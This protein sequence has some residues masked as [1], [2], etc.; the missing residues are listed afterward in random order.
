MNSLVLIEK[1]REKERMSISDFYL[2]PVKLYNR[3]FRDTKIKRFH[4]PIELSTDK[5]REEESKTEV[6]AR[7]A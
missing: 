4:L 2:R 3:L 5:Q 6:L 1:D 7:T